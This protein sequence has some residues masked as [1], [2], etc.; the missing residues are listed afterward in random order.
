MYGYNDNNLLE[1]KIDWALNFFPGTEERERLWGSR[2]I[3]Y[4]NEEDKNWHHFLGKNILYEVLNIMNKNPR[5]PTTKNDSFQIDMEDDNFVYIVKTQCWQK[6]DPIEKVLGLIFKY[7]DIPEKCKKPLKII[8]M[9]H[10][11]YELTTGK[12]TLFDNVAPKHQLFLNLAKEM[13]IT[14]VKF[15]DLVREMNQRR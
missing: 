8:C 1:T 6:P 12:F 15:S 3:G 14:Y 11:E 4:E 10:Q 5:Y 2:I 13:N 7:C 9:A